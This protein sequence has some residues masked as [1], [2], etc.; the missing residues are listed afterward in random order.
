MDLSF[1]TPE[2]RAL[3]SQFN[4]AGFDLRLVGGVV[5]DTIAGIPAKDVDLCTDATPDQQMEIYEANGHRWIETGA[6]HGTITVVLDGEPHEITSLRVDVS[7]DGRHAEVEF[8]NDW[9]V[10]LER[11]DLTINAMAMTFDGEIIDPFGGRQDLANGVIRFVGDAEQRIREDYLRILRYFRFHARFG[12]KGDFKGDHWQAVCENAQGLRQISRERVWSEVKQILKH[13]RG[14]AM[15]GVMDMCDIGQHMDLPKAGYTPVNHTR[16]RVSAP[17]LTMAAW[18]DWDDGTIMR[19]AQDWK[20]SRAETDHVEWI[21]DKINMGYDLRRLIA[22]DGAPREW[23]AEL[24]RLEDRDELSQF[25]AEHWVFEPFPVTGHD[26]MQRGVKP[27]KV[28]GQ[29]LRQLK[30]DWAA[31]GYTAT[32]RQLLERIG[33]G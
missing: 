11:R 3:R 10:D 12:R 31:S 9:Q 21:S 23:V 30:E 16:D 33:D 25:V 18:C 15:L 13:D 20:W 5:R 19:L 14:V 29:L 22:I 32:K 8:T 7:T 17:E 27:G 28:M 24:A 26:L 4:R 6:A 2:L 1:I